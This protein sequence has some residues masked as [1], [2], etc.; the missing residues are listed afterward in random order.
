PPLSGALKRLKWRTQ[1][2]RAMSG[3]E[4]AFRVRVALRSRMDRASLASGWAPRPAAL[5]RPGVPLFP[6][7]TGWREAWSREFRLDIPA[8]EAL[9]AGDVEIFGERIALGRQPDW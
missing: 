9:L 7:D 5:V 3:A 1:R 2:I 8:L 4:I 6:A